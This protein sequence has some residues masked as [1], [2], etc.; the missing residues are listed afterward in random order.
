MESMTL[1]KV[2]KD[3]VSR[4]QWIESRAAKYLY[5]NF[6]ECTDE[7][8]IDISHI[9]IDIMKKED[10]NSVN[11]LLD[12]NNTTISIESMREVRKDWVSISPKL[13]KVAIIGVSGFKTI[14]FKLM[15]NM[16]PF[17][18]IPFSTTEEAVSYLCR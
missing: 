14:L 5:I 17:K 6:Q 15:K 12:V 13:C 16:I 9:A 1:Q 10:L 3:L 2:E 8:R 11:L 18:T 7:E 4:V